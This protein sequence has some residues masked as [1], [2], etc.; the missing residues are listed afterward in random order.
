MSSKLL[1]LSVLFLTVGCNQS[2]SSL[3]QKPAPVKNKFD[4]AQV[5]VQENAQLPPPAAT[6][7][8]TSQPT[9]VPPNNSQTQNKPATNTSTSGSNSP[10]SGTKSVP[11]SSTP[12]TSAAHSDPETTTTA[13]AD[14]AASA[15]TK[16]ADSSSSSLGA[17]DIRT[18][19]DTSATKVGK[20]ARSARQKPATQEGQSPIDEKKVAAQAAARLNQQ[21]QSVENKET[22]RSE[23]EKATWTKFVDYVAEHGEST[24]ARDGFYVTL[25]HETS[26]DRMVDRVVNEF[27]VVG[28]PDGKGGFAF[29]RVHVAWENWKVNSES[30]LEGDQWFFLLSR[31]GNIAQSWRYHYTKDKADHVL[32]RPGVDITPEEAQK[33]WAEIRTAWYKRVDEIISAQAKK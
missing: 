3:K 12:T 32:S 25:K 9:S 19:P 33:K 15:S 26:P 8:S 30:N 5:P 28:G 17:L 11:S 23:E 2:S 27:S 4:M 14:A 10:F 6:P 1:V 13:K 16:V 7:N 31:D 18:T 20:P 21:A 29:T 24:E 22:G